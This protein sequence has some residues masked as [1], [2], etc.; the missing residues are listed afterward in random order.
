MRRFFVLTTIF[1]LVLLVGCSTRQP[2]GGQKPN[3][4]AEASADKEAVEG[5]QPASSVDKESLDE[6]YERVME[7]A[8]KLLQGRKDDTHSA[9]DG[10]R[11]YIV[12]Q[13]DVLY[14][15]AK[16]HIDRAG[17]SKT[18]KRIDDVVDAILEAN[19]DLDPRSL[20]EGQ[21]I[22]LPPLTP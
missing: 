17:L 1:A 5:E 10:S 21:M 16:D 20:Q 11:T 6:R 12:K 2:A 19:P 18:E 4:A 9:D 14:E 13:G 3:P 8:Q 15:I 7:E 22:S